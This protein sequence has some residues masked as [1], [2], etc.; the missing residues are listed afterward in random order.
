[1]GRARLRCASAGLVSIAVSQFACGGTD[2]PTRTPL[3]VTRTKLVESVT[4]SVAARISASGNFVLPTAEH[5][6][7]P[8]ISAAAAGEQAVAAARMFGPHV[9]GRLEDVHGSAIDFSGLRVA[10]VYYAVTPYEGVPEDIHPGTR[11]HFGP[12]YL[13]ILHDGNA[14]PTLAVFVSARNTDIEV[15]DTTIIRT[16]QVGGNAFHLDGIPRSLSDRVAT[17]ERAAVTVSN[18]TGRRAA[19]VP[20]L[21]LPSSRHSRLF[22]RWQIRVENPVS[23]RVRNTGR[24]V[25]TDTFYV[26]FLGEILVPAEVQPSTVPL[27]RA[28]S[29]SV[30]NRKPSRP[31]E[32]EAVDMKR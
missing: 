11:K 12:C 1:M 30:V 5:E 24:Q 9:R 3:L 21:L 4:P 17:P 7:F 15:A 10:A 27:I 22:A 16:P 26:G 14:R 19:T 25:T 20:E 18:A 31:V 29:R 13:V 23:A 2:E 6:P 8:Q 28:A 32:F